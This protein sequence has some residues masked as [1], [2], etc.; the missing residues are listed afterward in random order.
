M[1]QGVAV[2]AGQFGNVGRLVD[3][4]G[5]HQIL[6]GNC[7]AVDSTGSTEAVA[8]DEEGQ[9]KQNTKQRTAYVGI[10]VSKFVFVTIH[11]SLRMVVSI[12]CQDSATP[13]VGANSKRPSWVVCHLPSRVISVVS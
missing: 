12:I 10:P 3:V 8:G 13:L 7:Y 4:F 9:E 11:G 6:D 1:I 2:A 5:Y